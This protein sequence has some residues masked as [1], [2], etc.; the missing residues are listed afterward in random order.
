M[1]LKLLIHL[2][3]YY[4]ALTVSQALDPDKSDETDEGNHWTCHNMALLSVN[5]HVA[6]SRGVP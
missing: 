4:I 3:I 1:N 6:G 2:S 5:Y